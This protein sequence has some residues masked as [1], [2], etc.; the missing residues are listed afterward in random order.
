MSMI[1]EAKAIHNELVR[2]RRFLHENAETGMDVQ[3]GAAY[4]KARLAE[5]GYKPEDCGKNGVSAIAGGKNGV[6]V[7]AGGKQG[8]KTFLIRADM[9]A[10]PIAEE[11]DLSYK[12]NT[13]NMH[14]CGHDL[15]TAM[16][17]GAAQLLKDHEE[18]LCGSVKLM[19]QPGE[20]IMEGALSMIGAGILDDPAVDAAMMIHVI[21]GSDIPS[22]SVILSNTMASSDWFKIDVTGRGCHGA[23]SNMGVDP[24]NIL[25]HIYMSLQTLNAREIGPMVPLSLTIGQM[26]GGV[27]GNIIPDSAFMTGTLRTLNEGTRSFAKER[28]EQISQ[29]IARTFRGDAVVTFFRGCPAL[30]PDAELSA[31]ILGYTR[32]LLGDDLIV[33]QMDR[34]LFGMGSEDFAFISERVPGVLVALS[35]GAAGAGYQFPMH[36]PKAAFDE[37][38]LPVGA[39]LYAESAYRWL[40]GN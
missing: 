14:A 4:V 23:M 13:G 12:S 21:T 11:S 37:D 22:G 28:I 26:A 39:A 35:A 24:L 20:E 5:M 16:L 1:E 10:L 31:K 15:H 40:E 18:S 30:A 17:L 7:I 2:H 29:G 9:D 33:T 27:T 25:N 38:V 19:F 34:S 8:G 3:S 32:D 6:S 36:H